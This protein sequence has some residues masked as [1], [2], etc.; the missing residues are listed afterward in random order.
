MGYM[1]DLRKGSDIIIKDARPLWDDLVKAAAAD[2]WVGPGRFSWTETTDHYE[3]R[4]PVAWERCQHLLADYGFC[5]F[6]WLGRHDS[7]GLV[8]EEWGGDKI[9]SS[10]DDIWEVLARHAEPYEWEMLGEDGTIWQE[11]NP[12][13]VRRTLRLLLLRPFLQLRS[14]NRNGGV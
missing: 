6:Y 4:T 12:D 9:G 7:H 3:Q 2:D 5:G 10:W 11:S 13:G 1:A 8:I 14:T